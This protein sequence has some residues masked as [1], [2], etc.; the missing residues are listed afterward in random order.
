MLFT[1][2]KKKSLG[3]LFMQEK[4]ARYTFCIGKRMLRRTI[5]KKQKLSEPGVFMLGVKYMG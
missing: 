1:E 5:Y 3:R 4:S 2:R